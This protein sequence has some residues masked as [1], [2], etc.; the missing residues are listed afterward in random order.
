MTEFVSIWGCRVGCSIGEWD[1]GT[2]WHSVWLSQIYC[3]GLRFSRPMQFGAQALQI[4]SK[5]AAKLRRR[6]N[7][8]GPALQ[9]CNASS[10]YLLH[11]HGESANPSHTSYAYVDRRCRCV[12][13]ALHMYA[14]VYFLAQALQIGCTGIA[15]PRNSCTGTAKPLHRCFCCIGAAKPLHGRCESSASAHEIHAS[16]AEALQ[17]SEASA[18]LLAKPLRE[19]MGLCAA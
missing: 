18:R 10:G 14:S 4:R 9:I 12:K 6:C 15:H 19:P 16:A 2:L 3:P 5:G 17:F 13:H 11:R 8:A 7:S 1:G